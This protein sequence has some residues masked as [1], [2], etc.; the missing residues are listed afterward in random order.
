MGFLTQLKV[1]SCIYSREICSQ[2]YAFWRLCFADVYLSSCHGLRLTDFIGLY[3]A[4]RGVAGIS[5]QCPLGQEQ[6]CVCVCEVG[7]FTLTHC[8][9]SS[10][11]TWE[12]GDVY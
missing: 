4:H 5:D 8:D 10:K 11:C 9:S 6:A 3:K 12:K 7:F 2:H 1:F